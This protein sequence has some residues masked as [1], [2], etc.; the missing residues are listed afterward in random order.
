MS[1]EASTQRKRDLAAAMDHYQQLTG[2]GTPRPELLALQ[3]RRLV[4]T[5][6]EA[7]THSP[8]YRELYAGLEL[9]DDLDVRTLPVVSKAML[10]E[11]FDE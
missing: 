11:R 6:R 10:M 1:V 7:A 5:A 9:S 2:V 4:Q 3:Q 8:L